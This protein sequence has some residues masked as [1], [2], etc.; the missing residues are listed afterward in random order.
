M[1]LSFLKELFPQYTVELYAE[2]NSEW[3]KI[4][5]EE[6]DDLIKVYYDPEDFDVYCLFFATQHAHISEKKYLIEYAT[7][8]ANAE[9][10][11]IEFYENGTNIFGGDIETAL[12]NDLTYNSLQNRFCFPRIDICNLSFSVRAWNKEYCFD[13]VFIKDSSGIV[14]IVKKYIEE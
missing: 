1:H 5:N 10:A 7:A 11:A 9:I 6:F 12:L 14:Q 2:D 13:G 8:F 4:E 3:A